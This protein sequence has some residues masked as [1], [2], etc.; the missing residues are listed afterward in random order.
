MPP[1]PL[2]A[3]LE[4]LPLVPEPSHAPRTPLMLSQ[5]K[6]EKAHGAVATRG[7]V[8]PLLSEAWTEVAQGGLECHSFSETRRSLV[9]E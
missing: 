1:L 4:E 9:R 3:G 5:G 8:G 7:P 2:G 6:G